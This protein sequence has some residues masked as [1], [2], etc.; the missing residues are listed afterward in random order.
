[1]V[2]ELMTRSRVRVRGRQAPEP[3]ERAECEAEPH[4]LPTLRGRTD[5]LYVYF[6]KRAFVEYF[7]DAGRG[8]HAFFLC[9][10]IHRVRSGKLDNDPSGARLRPSE[11]SLVDNR[12]AVSGGEDSRARV[13]V[14]ARPPRMGAKIVC[15]MS[16]IRLLLFS[17][18]CAILP[19][20]RVSSDKIKFTLK[21]RLLYFSR[22]ERKTSSWQKR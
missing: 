11:L 12:G 8:W 20:G 9:V 21:S 6:V 10:F 14:R 4:D 5:R 3:R 17:L 7:T 16:D 1:M 13:R 2:A 15:V 22:A 18:R 19:F